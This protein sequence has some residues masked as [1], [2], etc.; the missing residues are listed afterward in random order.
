MKPQWNLE[1]WY[2]KTRSKVTMTL[3]SSLFFRMEIS[4]SEVN[5]V[6]VPVNPD[7]DLINFI[8]MG[9]E[10]PFRVSVPETSIPLLCLTIPLLLKVM[11]GK[12][13]VSK[14]FPLFKDQSRTKLP[15]FKVSVFTVPSKVEFSRLSQSMTETLLKPEMEPV[16]SF[17]SKLKVTVADLILEDCPWIAHMGPKHKKNTNKMCFIR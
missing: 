7:V 1:I 13:S 8:S 6:V 16:T 17:F 5:R 14:Y 15:V 4:K 12:L 9:F 3:L 10:I 2:Y 11:V